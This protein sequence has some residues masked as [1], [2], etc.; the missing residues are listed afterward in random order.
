MTSFIATKTGFSLA[1]YFLFGEGD[2]E[3]GTTAFIDEQPENFARTR[4]EREGC[5][6]LPVHRGQRRRGVLAREA[7]P[8]RR[9]DLNSIPLS[10]RSSNLQLSYWNTCVFDGISTNCEDWFARTGSLISA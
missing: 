8:R 6:V 4:G 5:G 1:V 2:A 10:D 7:H 9:P 3:L